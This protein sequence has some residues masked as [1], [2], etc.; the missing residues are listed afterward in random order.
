MRATAFRPRSVTKME[1]AGL[2][3]SGMGHGAQFMR[4]PRYSQTLW[5]RLGR[6]TYPGTLN[7][8][9]HP[10]SAEH[11]KKLRES[12]GDRVP[13]FMASGKEMGGVRVWTAKLLA[14][15]NP[16]GVDVLLIW[17]EKTGHP[18]DI[19]EVVAGHPL[20]ARLGLKDGDE[21]RIGL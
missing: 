16:D 4:Q 10:D 2:V 1:L 18:D 14:G 5:L 8:K 21:I 20:R 15:P 11:W 17:P 19:L 9:L 6:P 3:C 7:V 12:G 13:G